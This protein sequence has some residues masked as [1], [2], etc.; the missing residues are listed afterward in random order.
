LCILALLG[1]SLPSCLLPVLIRISVT[2][3]ISFVIAGCSL[4]LGGAG[5]RTCLGNRSCVVKLALLLG[6][7]SGYYV[8]SFL[9]F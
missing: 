8:L 6:L 7:L 5:V 1:G 2:S 3:S 9:Y 4:G